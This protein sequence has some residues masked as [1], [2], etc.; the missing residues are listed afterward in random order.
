MFDIKDINGV[1]PAIITPFD[2][3]ENFS[4]ERFEKLIEYLIEVGVHGLYITG[5]TGE[6][7]LMTPEERKEV[8]EVAIK[9]VAG[10]IPTIVH[11]G[12]LSTKISIDLAKHAYETGAD[13]ISS[14]PPYYWKFGA[15]Q[16]YQYY[17]D[18]A[19]SVPI[20]MIVYKVALIDANLGLDMV[21]KLASIENVKGIKYTSVNHYE[22]QRIKERLGSDFKIYSGADEMA[23]SGLTMES[24]GIIGSFYSLM[25]EIFI[26]IYN[27][28]TNGNYEE[29]RQKQII[30]NDIIEI[31]LKYD[32]Y[33]AMK[34]ALKWLGVDAGINRRP[35]LPLSEETKEKLT[36]E[37]KAL[38]AK[39]DVSIVKFMNKI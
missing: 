13:A 14:V 18:L 25:P 8:V 37:L 10:R 32:Y 7:F 17:N 9:T 26:E 20:P 38:K 24:D 35:F 5:S 15:E 1:I 23:F 11:V 2:E 3:D 6:G 36:E 31:F 21:E 4:K 30:A 29:A 16:M 28:C 34:E 19:S 39:K 33:P 22:L 27:D 12:A